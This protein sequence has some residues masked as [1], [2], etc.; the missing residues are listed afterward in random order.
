MQLAHWLKYSYNYRC[1]EFVVVFMVSIC[2]IFVY[3][4]IFRENVFSYYNKV[5]VNEFF[6]RFCNKYLIS[7]IKKQ[8]NINIYQKICQCVL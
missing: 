7:Y 5:Y 8:L 2:E 3:Q 4:A 1:L 6:M